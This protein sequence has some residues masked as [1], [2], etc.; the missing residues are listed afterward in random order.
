MAKPTNICSSNEIPTPVSLT[1]KVCRVPG[2]SLSLSW[3]GTEI[4]VTD[5]SSYPN[6]EYP[7]NLILPETTTFTLKALV[8]TS[9][10]GNVPF[11]LQTTVSVTEPSISQ[12][13]QEQ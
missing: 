5:Y 6:S 10:G 2:C 7:A 3:P 1:W 9:S 11:Q 8:P 12:I 4:D 13:L